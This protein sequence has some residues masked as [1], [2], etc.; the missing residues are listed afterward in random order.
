MSLKY[1]DVNSETLDNRFAGFTHGH[2][3]EAITNLRAELDATQS[4]LSSTSDIQFNNATVFGDIIPDATNTTGTIGSAANPW[5]TAWIDE[6]HLANNTLYLGDTPVLGTDSNVVEV[7]A[8]SDQGITIKTTGTGETK[9]ISQ[10]GIEI[11]NSG[12]NGQIAIQSTGAGG[13]VSFGATQQLNFTAPDTN[14]SGDLNVT[15]GAQFNAATFTGDVVF[16][17]DNITMDTTN[18]VA[19]DNRITL[20]SGEQG[21]GVTA[22]FAGFQIDRGN[23]NDWH[24]VFNEF[25]DEFQFGPIGGT[26][27]IVVSKTFVETGLNA[28]LD[29]AVFNNTYTAAD[30]LAK[31]KTVDGVNSGLDA[32]TVAGYT[33]AELT[34]TAAEIFDAVLSLDGPGTLLN[35][36]LLDGFEAAYFAPGATTYNKTEVDTAVNVKLDASAYT[37]ADVL[38]KIK[39]VDGA[40][41][42]LDADTL[43]AHSSSYFAPQATTYNKT[44]VDAAINNVI[45][46]APGA[47]NTLNE[48]AAALG[49]DPNFATTVTNNIAT[50]LPTSAY[51][52]A[53][54]LAKIK[55]V[56]GP[57]SGLNADYLDSHSASYFAV[58][59]STYT[60][61]EVNN[62]LSNKLNASSYTA[63]DVL[64]KI[65]TVDGPGS[66]LDADT[67]DG[68]TTT[69]FSIAGHAHDTRYMRKDTNTTHAGNITPT[70]NNSKYLG[71]ASYKYKGVYA[72]TFYGNATSAN[73][74]DLAEKYTIKSKEDIAAGQ[75]VVISDTDEV[76]CMI[77]EVYGSQGVIGAVSTNPAFRMNEDL[78][79]GEFVA[80][81]GRIPCRVVGAV[82]KGDP[83]VSAP[84]GCAI[85]INHRDVPGDIKFLQGIIL[86]KALASSTSE[87]VKEIEVIIL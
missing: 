69:Y 16:Q 3:I 26:Q 64:A 23:L 77:S 84:N 35:A 79:G 41:S 32:D 7:K 24:F 45:D 8:D 57:G 51:T 21:D 2:A 70:S 48:L 86:G 76:D 38:A 44:E 71:S 78:E 30:I 4:G 19:E 87:D 55:T 72:T 40:G 28:K 14:V 15:G 52:A 65:K 46:S 81:K 27:Q 1:Y 82:K 74:A 83:L 68:H 29:A 42:G 43:D 25:N 9:M 33:A 37:A 39:T 6:L 61:S 47:L 20:N 17:G 18:F 56:D 54:V 67:L 63:A 53:D 12:L 36:D 73:Y 58:A 80:L 60:E 59:S 49:D 31:L 50:K 22:G 5:S 75:I 13:Q 62:L 66:G 85:S 10:N 11:S 34:Q